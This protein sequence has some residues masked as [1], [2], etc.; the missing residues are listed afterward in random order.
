[1][2]LTANPRLNTALVPPTNV[3]S[4]QPTNPRALGSLDASTAVE[5]TLP[6]P[7]RLATALLEP[8]TS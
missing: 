1:M 6:S 4:D 8:L 2:A 5:A 3:D 7:P